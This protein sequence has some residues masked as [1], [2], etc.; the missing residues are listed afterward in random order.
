[1]KTNC[2]VFGFFFGTLVASGCCHVNRLTER[3]EPVRT[4]ALTL[5]DDPATELHFTRGASSHTRM[6]IGPLARTHR[7]VLQYQDLLQEMGGGR[8]RQHLHQQLGRVLTRQ[9][10]WQVGD[11]GG[12][13]LVELEELV[14]NA[15]DPNSPVQVTWRLTTRLQDAADESLIW[16]DCEDFQQDLGALSMAQLLGMGFEERERFVA[17][18]AKGLAEH[19][20]SKLAEDGA[21]VVGKP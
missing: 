4:F 7:S 9:L 14:F 5:G 3:T 20:A 8:L 15:A 13:L 11:E 6:L 12:L 21:S 2:L 17:E 19:L 10:G 1:M 16:R 18:L